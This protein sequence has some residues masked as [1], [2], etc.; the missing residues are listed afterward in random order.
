VA[1]FL[2]DTLHSGAF[3]GRTPDESYVVRCGPETTTQRD[4]ENGLVVI[5][6]GFAPLRPAK[7]VVFRVR[8]R[9]D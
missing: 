9:W 4:I 8:H 6:V 5:E 2:E 3:A 7:F 1:A